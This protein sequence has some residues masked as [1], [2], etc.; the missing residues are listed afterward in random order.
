MTQPEAYGTH[1]IE[2]LQAEI[3][4]L[5]ELVNRGFVRCQGGGFVT[6]PRVVVEFQN[7][8]DAQALHRALLFIPSKA[9]A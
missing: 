8:E 5:R 2:R 9:D 6:G 3:R 4:R 1:Q 7:L